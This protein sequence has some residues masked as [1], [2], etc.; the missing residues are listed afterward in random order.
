M[1]TYTFSS[2]IRNAV[3]RL[4][5]EEVCGVLRSRGFATKKEEGAFP[6]YT[7]TAQAAESSRADRREALIAELIR[8]GDSPAT[9]VVKAAR[10]SAS[11]ADERIAA[12]RKEIEGL[13]KT[14]DAAIKSMGRED[15]AAVLSELKLVENARRG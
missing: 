14:V 1:D 12:R 2:M 7:L 4:G 5:H 15:V 9:A 6:A 3:G 11:E 10:Q 13:G 8:N